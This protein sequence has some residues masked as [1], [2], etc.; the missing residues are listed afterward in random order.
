MTARE[1]ADLLTKDVEQ[2][3]GLICDADGEEYIKDFIYRRLIVFLTEHSTGYCVSEGPRWEARQYADQNNYFWL[4]C[5]LCNQWY[6]GH[7][8]MDKGL[9]GVF[10]NNNASISTCPNCEQEARRLNK[11][12]PNGIALK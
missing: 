3:T 1:F 5:V 9:V 8:V 4:P 12:F 10:I 6:G 11:Q 7:E 2:L